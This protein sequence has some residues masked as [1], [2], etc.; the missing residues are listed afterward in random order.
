M[1]TTA[2]GTLQ[3]ELHAVDSMSFRVWGGQVRRS[4]KRAS[5]LLSGWKMVNSP[6]ELSLQ[7]K[8]PCYYATL[9]TRDAASW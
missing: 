4:K 1:V 2:M 8:A 5:C 6:E 7:N 9:M 3:A